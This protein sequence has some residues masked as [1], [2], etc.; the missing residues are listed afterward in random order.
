VVELEEGLEFRLTRMHWCLCQ[1]LILIY[2]PPR[3]FGP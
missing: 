2:G 3:T 1:K